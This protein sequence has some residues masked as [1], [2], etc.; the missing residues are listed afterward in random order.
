MS[1]RQAIGIFD[2]GIGG[3]TVARA[4]RKILPN[5]SIIYLGDTA[6]LPYGDKSPELIRHFAKGISKFLL[7]KNCKAIVIACNTASAHAYKTV[8][9]NCG[10]NI[11]V[12]N[13]I[14][15]IAEYVS[16]NLAQGKV[17]V[18]ATKGT[19][20][21]Q[22]YRKRI[23]KLNPKLELVSQATPLLAPMIEEGFFNNNISQTVINSYLSKRRF[24]NLDTLILGCTH[25]PLIKKEVK[26]FYKG[27]TTVIDSANVVA[28]YVKDVLTKKNILAGSNSQQSE[29]YITDYTKSFEKS[30]KI[31]FGEK[32]ETSE[33]RL[34]D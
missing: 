3:M 34:W 27:K 32:I 17:G 10:A 28:E 31:F 19:I 26:N 4:I 18:I 24:E 22:V 1:N 13:V 8:V 2:S 25:Y 20:Y 14:D 33:L 11:P 23:K 15:P 7:D 6:H 9:E 5:E 21:S 30:T 12:I 29:V 16:K